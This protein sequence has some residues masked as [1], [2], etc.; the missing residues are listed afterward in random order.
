MTVPPGNG[1]FVTG[2]R[3]HSGWFR[4]RIVVL[5]ADSS[6]YRMAGQIR[7][8]DDFT[9]SRLEVAVMHPLYSART[10]DPSSSIRSGSAA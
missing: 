9:G 6:C 7:S 3:T 10:P 4:R 1:P 8:V 2:A 5:N